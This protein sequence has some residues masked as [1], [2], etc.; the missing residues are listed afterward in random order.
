MKKNTAIYLILTVALAVAVG[1][2]CLLFSQRFSVQMQQ[3]A[4]MRLEELMSAN[5]ASFELQ[6]GE[7]IKKVRTL[8]D[9]L[10]ASGTLG[11]DNQIILLQAAAENNGLLRCALAYPDGS[12]VTHDGKNDGNVSGDAFFQANMQGKFFITDPRPAVVDPSKTVML[13]ACPVLENGAVA[14]SII[15]SYLCDDMDRIFN[16]SFLD[17]QGEM[18]VI[19]ENGELLIGHSGYADVEE[20]LLENL[21]TVCAH[22][23]HAAA[24]CMILSGEGG[25]FTLNP[26]DDGDNLLVRYEKVGYNDWYM[27]SLVPET[28]AVKTLVSA[29]TDQRNLVITLVLFGGAY[30]I[31][32]FLLWLSRRKGTDR[33]TGIPN[34]ARF[35]HRAKHI[36]RRYKDTVFVCVKTDIKNFKLINRV[37]DFSVGDQVIKNIA[38][39]LGEVLTEPDTTFARAGAD[40]FVLLLPYKGRE[41]LDGKRA[42]FIA[43]FQNLM[44]EDFT[45]RMEFPTGQYILQPG[46][47]ARADITEVLEKC[48]FAHRAAKVRDW[49]HNIVDYEKDLEKEALLEKAIE[50]KMSAALTNEEFQLYLQPKHRVSDEALCGAEALVRWEVNGQFYMHPTAFIPILERN[51]FI[52]KIDLYMFER[53]VER[54]RLYL[55]EGLEPVPISVNFSRIHL[56]NE[57]FVNEL[58]AIVDRYGVP[59]HYLEVELTESAVFENVD[60]IIALISELHAAGFTMSMDDFGSGYSCLALL[61]DLEVDALKLDKGFFDSSVNPNRAKIVISNIMRMAKE[62]GVNTVA[63]GIETREQVEMLQELECDVIQGYYYSKPIPGAQLHLVDEDGENNTAS[64]K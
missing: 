20:N 58:C 37:Y 30:L 38:E 53:A 57:G 45:T 55:D 13:F 8:A 2:S 24:D 3:D 52:V 59:R 50:D 1:I 64:P 17:G 41:L 48:N 7:Q 44:G 49:D 10:G 6:V 19:K 34:L 46:D 56:N 21:R 32:I 47:M 42:E 29:S 11:S 36:L 5:V 35:K 26:P 16:L 4:R 31:V 27:F 43:R 62:L 28:A 15:Y 14:G 60:R 18:L 22:A 33:L 51:G 39:A 12:F 40:D 9:Y 23:G 54:L 63:E 61:K 25:E